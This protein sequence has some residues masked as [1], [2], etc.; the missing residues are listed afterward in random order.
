MIRTLHET[1]FF[2]NSIEK[3]IKEN[4]LANAEIGIIKKCNS[5]VLIMEKLGLEK[6]GYRIILMYSN[7]F[8]DYKPLYD[9]SINKDYIPVSK[10]T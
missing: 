7:L 8:S 4:I 10:F 6:F 2:V 3:L 5:L 1:N 9:V